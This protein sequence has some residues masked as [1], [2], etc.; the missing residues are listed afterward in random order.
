MS[1]AQSGNINEILLP[2]CI[3]PIFRTCVWLKVTSH[4]TVKLAILTFSTNSYRVWRFITYILS[5]KLSHKQM[6]YMVI[7]GP[8]TLAKYSVSKYFHQ[9]LQISMYCGQDLNLD[10]RICTASLFQSTEKKF[11]LLCHIPFR[12]VSMKKI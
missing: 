10:R 6:S 1:I 2:E 11:I 12:I 4:G 9:S 5:F 7:L 3:L 8:Q